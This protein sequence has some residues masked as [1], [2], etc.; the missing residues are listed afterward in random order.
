MRAFNA[1]EGFGKEQDQLSEKFFNTPLK[2]GPTDGKLIDRKTVNEAIEEYY[3]QREWDPETG[4]PT[5]K[6][7]EA[8]NIEWV[9]DLLDA[10]Q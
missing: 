10:N 3:R 9:E 6:V 4:H 1:R 8:L 5:R 2:G 7:L